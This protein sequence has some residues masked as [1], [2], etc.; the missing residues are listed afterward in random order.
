[1]KNLITIKTAILAKEL[2]FDEPVLYYYDGSDMIASQAENVFDLKNYNIHH[3]STSR[4]APTQS[5]LQKWLR[6]TYNIHV[7]IIYVGEHEDGYPA[8]RGEVFKSLENGKRK[9]YTEL[10]SDNEGDFFIFRSYENC[11]ENGLQSA[12]TLIKTE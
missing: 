1:M 2:G 3:G 11:L 9:K 7:N 10:R 5:L 8:F 4:S 12:L 6:D